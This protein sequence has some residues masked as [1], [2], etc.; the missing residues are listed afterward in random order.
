MG[1]SDNELLRAIDEGIAGFQCFHAKS[2]GNKT[3]EKGIDW[4]TGN[5]DQIYADPEFFD[6]INLG[7]T[8]ITIEINDDGDLKTVYQ[9]RPLTI[10]I[11]PNITKVSIVGTED[12]DLY[13][14]K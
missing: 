9:A 4:A 3:Y 6:I 2:T 1:K 10:S 13:L 5:T 11:Y 7:T 12:F 14:L 8:D